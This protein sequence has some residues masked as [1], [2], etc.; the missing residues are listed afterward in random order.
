[1]MKKA[2]SYSP[3]RAYFIAI[4][5]EPT[6]LYLFF[7]YHHNGVK[8]WRL[9]SKIERIK[10]LTQC[11]TITTQNSQYVLAITHFIFKNLSMDKFLYCKNGITPDEVT[12]ITA[13][14]KVTITS[15]NRSLK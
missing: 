7:E 9:T 11:T 5:D 1:M 4:K 10:L 8:C 13:L 12:M 14:K 6:Y 15:S 3:E 2:V